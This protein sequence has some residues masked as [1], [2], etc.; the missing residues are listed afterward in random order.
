MQTRLH[1]F[2]TLADYNNS[3]PEDLATI[4]KTLRNSAYDKKRKRAY[5]EAIYRALPY[6]HATRH[7]DLLV[8]HIEDGDD[9]IDPAR[10]R[11]ALADI[12]T[13]VDIAIN[14]SDFSHGSYLYGIFAAVLKEFERYI[15]EDV[16]KNAEWERLVRYCISPQSR[17]RYFHTHHMGDWRHGSDR[18]KFAERY[19][20]DEDEVRRLHMDVNDYFNKA[21]A[22]FD[23]GTHFFGGGYGHRDTTANTRDAM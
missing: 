9:N 17:V 4:F 12:N 1:T 8:R 7:A 11:S 18:L 23:K 13:A 6:P 14:K 22:H 16:A 21:E 5:R 10:L 2:L 20:L 3:L 15:P 19:T